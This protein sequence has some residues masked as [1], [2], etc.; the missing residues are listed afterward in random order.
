MQPGNTI[1]TI[2]P[3]GLDQVLRQCIRD[4]ETHIDERTAPMNNAPRVLCTGINAGMADKSQER[5]NK[6]R[7]QRKGRKGG[8]RERSITCLAALLIKASVMAPLVAPAKLES[9]DGWSKRMI[10]SRAFAWALEHFRSALCRLRDCFKSRPLLRPLSLTA[11]FCNQ[12]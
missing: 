11:T 2:W 1:Q 12:T 3:I 10:R 6:N 4:S 7:Q 8:R 5:E 9:G